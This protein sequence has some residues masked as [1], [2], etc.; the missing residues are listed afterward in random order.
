M[1]TTTTAKKT[2]SGGPRSQDLPRGQTPVRD[3]TETARRSKRPKR[4]PCGRAGRLC[5]SIDDDGEH[6]IGSHRGRC[7]SASALADLRSA[8]GSCSGA[9]PPAPPPQRRGRGCRSAAPPPRTSPSAAPGRKRT[10][11][12]ALARA[13]ARLR[14]RAYLGDHHS[15]RFGPLSVFFSLALEHQ[16]PLARGAILQRELADDA[17]EGGDLGFAHRRRRLTQEK[18][19]RVEPDA[20]AASSLANDKNGNRKTPFLPPC[21]FNSFRHGPV[22]NVPNSPANASLRPPDTSETGRAPGATLTC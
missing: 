7:A 14:T 18:Q 1:T 22:R 11:A 9:P 4:A 10:L 12:R 5:G 17:A 2:D 19:E 15:S 6:L 20:H 13:L 16:H 8:S 21:F 3:A